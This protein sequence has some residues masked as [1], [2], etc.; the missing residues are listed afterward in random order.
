MRAE[1][2]VFDTNVLISAFLSSRGKP[3]ACLTWVL[4]NGEILASRELLAELETS[5]ARPKFARYAT[6]ATRNAY[7]ADLW[8]NAAL[9]PV[10]GTISVC[11]D[12]DDDKVLEIA[13]AGGADCI[14][15]GDQ[16]LLVLDPFQGI[17]ILTPAAFL[18]ALAGPP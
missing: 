9:I 7:I 3:Y 15:T 14:V 13:V 17:P 5:L 10:V 1:R 18:V 11:R 2:V 6:E 12:P 8:Q 16:D 4:L